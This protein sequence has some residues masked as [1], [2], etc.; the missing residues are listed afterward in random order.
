MSAEQEVV[1][2]LKNDS[3]DVVQTSCE[4]NTAA[5][6]FKFNFKITFAQTLI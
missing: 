6:H 4:L 5:Q 1:H 3:E 2:I